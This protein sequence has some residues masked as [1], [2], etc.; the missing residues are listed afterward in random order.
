[1]FPSLKESFGIVLVEAQSCGVPVIAMDIPALQEIAKN[2]SAILVPIDDVKVFTSE[3]LCLMRN[4]SYYHRL[5][6]AGLE[7]VKNYDIQHYF[8]QLQEIY[9]RLLKEQFY[10]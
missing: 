5:K 8:D 6:E 3:I 7:N 2:D 1:M 9:Q 10:Q 4:E